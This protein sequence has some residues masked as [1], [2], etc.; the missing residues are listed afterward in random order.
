MI[1]NYRCAVVFPLKDW[2][3]SGKLRWPTHSLHHDCIKSNIP[4][5]KVSKVY[6]YQKRLD[7]KQSWSLNVHGAKTACFSPKVCAPW[8][9][10][11]M[12]FNAHAEMLKCSQLWSSAHQCG[13]DSQKPLLKGS[14]TGWLRFSNKKGPNQLSIEKF[15]KCQHKQTG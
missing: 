10:V 4:K 9:L 6:W 5:P 14:V 3:I 11:R 1:I 13:F 12:K 7:R 2:G 15:N 8:A